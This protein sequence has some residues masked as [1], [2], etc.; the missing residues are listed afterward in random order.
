MFEIER[1]WIWFVSG[2]GETAAF[3]FRK[4]MVD[5]KG[6]SELCCVLKRMHFSAVRIILLAV[7]MLLLFLKWS[8]VMLCCVII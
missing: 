3:P 6:L 7:R 1:K 5:Y 4:W 2:G 8:E